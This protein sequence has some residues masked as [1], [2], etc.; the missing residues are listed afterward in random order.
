MI[1]NEDEGGQ[2]EVVWTCHEE[3]PRVFRK[4]MEMELL[5]KRKRGRP[6]RRFLTVVKEDI[7][8]VGAKET[9]VENRMVWRK[10]I[11]C[12]YP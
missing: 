4:T 12:G 11:C 9:D 8:E 5:R 3:R 7:G 10:I 1:R 2:A 6:K